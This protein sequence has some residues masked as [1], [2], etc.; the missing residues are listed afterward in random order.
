MEEMHHIHRIKFKLWVLAGKPTSGIV[1]DEMTDTRKQFKSK[2][3]S[4]QDRQEQ[5][6]MNN[7]ASNHSAKKFKDI[8]KNVN[9][10]NVKTSHPVSV[11]G[12]SDHKAVADMFKEQR[13]SIGR[14]GVVFAMR[15]PL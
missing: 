1:Y 8:W 11:G 10:L 13:S 14:Q 12:V 9:R 15:V 4:C 2:L 7:L 5:L 3:K 6:K